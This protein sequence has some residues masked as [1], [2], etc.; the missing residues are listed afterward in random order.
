MTRLKWVVVAMFL[1]GVVG[2]VSAQAAFAFEEVEQPVGTTG[3][4]KQSSNQVLEATEEKAPNTT[5]GVVCTEASGETEV[6]NNLSVA[7]KA[8]KYGGCTVAGAK[9]AVTNGCTILLDLNK[10]TIKGDAAIKAAGCKITIEVA[11]TGCKLII[12]G[13]QKELEEITFEKNN[14]ATKEV[15]VEA[16]VKGV[17]FSSATGKACGF[18]VNAVVGLAAFKGKSISKG[19]NLK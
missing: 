3:T 9:A 15:T 14:A 11:S 16:K 6:V 4:V 5:V 12:E 18:A 19:I 10:G 8:L 13:E 2:A 7:V 17:K 1:V